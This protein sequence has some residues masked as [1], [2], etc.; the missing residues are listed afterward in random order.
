VSVETEVA[1]WVDRSDREWPVTVV[2]ARDY[3]ALATQLKDTQ[4]VLAAC[5][6]VL[7]EERARAGSAHP[8][9]NE[10]TVDEVY[11]VVR[12]RFGGT[13][14][15]YT[16]LARALYTFVFMPPSPAETPVVHMGLD[17]ETPHE[18]KRADCARCSQ[19]AP[20]TGADTL[21]QRLRAYRGRE[22]ETTECFNGIREEAAA[23]IERLRSAE[24]TVAEP[25]LPFTHWSKDPLIPYAGCECRSCVD[26]RKAS[27]G[28]IHCGDDEH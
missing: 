9:S 26:A 25:V 3:D 28:C 21:L 12:E 20:T 8:S 22:W 19:P 7:Q 4:A 27:G 23:E 2:S 17:G 5:N 16:T 18:G 11:R 6:K 15:A 14:P 13:M 10:P 24:K 1:R